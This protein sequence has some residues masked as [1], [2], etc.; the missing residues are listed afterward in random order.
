MQRL[1]NRSS[2]LIIVGLLAVWYAFQFPA[3]LLWIAACVAMHYFLMGITHPFG[4]RVF[5]HV[6]VEA[7]WK[8]LERVFA[9]IDVFYG[10]ASPIAYFMSHNVHHSLADR[11][12]DPY[13]S[14]GDGL[15]RL[16]G[17]FS[18]YNRMSM[19][20]HMLQQRIGARN[21]WQQDRFYVFLQRYAN[22]LTVCW[23][24]LLFAIGGLN[25][26]IYLGLIPAATCM[27]AVFCV[28]LFSHGK[29]GWRGYRNKS[30]GNE[31]SALNTP[32]LFPF[33]LSEAWHGNHHWNPSQLSFKYRWWELDPSAVIIKLLC[34][35]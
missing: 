20:R 28:S 33:S 4:H 6:V 34:K 16:I 19:E 1:F 24:I 21:P 9:A 27:L 3:G 29:I 15:W 35:P 13:L 5:A 10:G 8:T 18:N 12:D 31:C 23:Y 30:F 17:R 7:R 14:N 22:Q 25:C 26:L 11:L 32:W 2:V